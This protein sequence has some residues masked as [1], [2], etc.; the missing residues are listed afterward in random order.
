MHSLLFV[1]QFFENSRQL[2]SQLLWPLAAALVILA[3][4]WIRKL[5]RTAKERKAR[6]WPVFYATVQVA[7]VAESNPTSKVKSYKGWLTYFYKNPE[8]QMGELEKYFRS[9]ARAQHW[10]EQFRG[11]QVVVHV[12]PEDPSD[13]MLLESDLE[14][15]AA[16]LA[17]YIKAPELDEGWQ[18]PLEPA[19]QLTQTMLVLCGVGELASLVGLAGCAVM[20]LL[21]LAKGT[22]WL[23]K[24]YQW[25][26]GIT[27][28]LATLTAIPVLRE[29]KK[30]DAGKSF[31]KNLSEWCP[32]W[33]SWPVKISTTVASFFP[34]Y[35]MIHFY[36]FL[37][38]IP[39]IKAFLFHYPYL[40]GGWLFLLTT[41][42]HT[43]VLRSQ[44][45]SRLSA[46]R[47]PESS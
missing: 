45:Q 14:G 36:T 12:N 25:A 18:E 31:L 22:V 44:E 21:S 42:F 39:W 43:A 6:R 28:A 38:K 17:P 30:D 40:I 35:K 47:H 46:L 29:L 27:L 37:F 19:P 34:F 11:R 15:L 24:P 5:R 8:M 2:L 3:I 23:P 32:P 9:K 33:L 16:P 20:F 26:A 10:V 7:I 1:R 41:G 4:G 13:S